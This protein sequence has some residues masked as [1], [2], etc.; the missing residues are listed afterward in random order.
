[1]IDFT[2]GSTAK[3]TQYF[4]LD[5]APLSAA[6]VTVTVTNPSGTEIVSSAACT[7]FNYGYYYYSINS[8]L[9]S[10]VGT[11]TCNWT[12][13][14]AGTT[15]TRTTIFNVGYEPIYN[16]SLADIRHMVSRLVEGKESFYKGI[17][18]ATSNA[19]TIV[20]ASRV[21][22][23]DHFKG[24]WVYLYNGTGVGQERRIVNSDSSSGSLSVLPVLNPSPDSTTRYEIHREFRVEDYNDA[25]KLAHMEVMK[26][27][28]IPIK[29]QPI[30][31]A[32]GQ[33]EY[34][35]PAGF[36]H[37]YEVQVEATTGKY[38]KVTPA[39]WGVIAND[40][41]LTLHSNIVD[42]YSGYNIRLLGL[43]SANIPNL[44]GDMIDVNPEYLV[45][46][47]A[48]ILCSS[49]IKSAEASPAGWQVKYQL[50]EVKAEA[51]KTQM[52]KSLPHNAKRVEW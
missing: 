2:P 22:P 21:E 18:N 38:T 37:V 35:I 46:K 25:V 11:Y 27:V 52:N 19:T 36:S 16:T 34:D 28:L 26:W 9:T 47:A 39:C 50:N 49:R 17:A 32:S 1:M 33:Y 8:S 44:D 7:E 31:L 20:D 43:R 15:I 45:H 42:V 24:M 3:I 12:A 30:A 40:R 51:M 41:K 23:D 48:A 4:E 6:T 14:K 5:G 13:V 10:S 29:S